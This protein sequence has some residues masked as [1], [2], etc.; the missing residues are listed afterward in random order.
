M[1]KLFEQYMDIDLVQL[2]L[3]EDGITP[4]QARNLY[5]SFLSSHSV[6]HWGKVTA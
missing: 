1:D 4:G 3:E 6:V 5:T 2:W